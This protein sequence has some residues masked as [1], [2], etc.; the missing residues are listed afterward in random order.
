[1]M[2]SCLITFVFAL[3]LEASKFSVVK[4]NKV[5]SAMIT[6]FERI[7][8]HLSET[9]REVW[10]I[11]DI[12]DEGI[13][14]SF[15]LKNTK[16]EN[17]AVKLTNLNK[18]KQNQLELDTSAIFILKSV[19]S[20]VKINQNVV[21]TNDFHKTLQY[22]VYCLNATLFELY[23]LPRSK[24][25]ILQY[26]LI[27]EEKSFKLLTMEYF[28]PEKCYQLNFFEVNSFNKIA[29]KWKNSII[30]V[31]KFRNFHECYIVVGFVW[32]NPAFGYLIQSNGTVFHWGYNYK[33]IEALETN[34]NF[35]LIVN[36]ADENERF[37]APQI[38]IDFKVNMVDLSHISASKIKVF[39]TQ[40]HIF[41]ASS[42][43]VPPGAEFDA[44]EKL[45]LPFDFTTWILI[46]A[47]F[48]SAYI[49]ILVLYFMKK[50]IREVVFGESVTTPSLNVTMIF[51]GI[52]Q[53][54]LPRKVFTRV[55][56]MLF[57][58]FCLIIRTAWQSMMFEFMNKVKK[59]F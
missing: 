25:L 20:L 36:P 28:S 23:N 7:T 53:I 18:I 41:T 42:I 50:S 12:V 35:S 32:Q 34:L 59:M 56:T 13:I 29:K 44:Y 4:G 46:S 57:I 48:L 52:S 6:A 49:T 15:I 30:S 31:K 47:T 37:L 8:K 11:S 24:I 19:N 17:I 51:F 22:F 9:N 3:H 40:P 45:L 27:D 58:L 43:A 38:K 5:S 16:S 14:N 54:V 39:F 55:L 21:F 2:K 1:M 33:M 10:I 26:F